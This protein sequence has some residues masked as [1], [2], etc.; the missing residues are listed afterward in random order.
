M[1]GVGA[2]RHLDHGVEVMIGMAIHGDILSL[3]HRRP[4]GTGTRDTFIRRRRQRRSSSQCMRIADECGYGMVSGMEWYKRGLDRACIGVWL[5]GCENCS[6]VNSV[7]K[8]KDYEF[9][10][11]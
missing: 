2:V 9:M 4:G 10:N 5:Q 6:S 11:V 8:G 1:E 7:I 3:R